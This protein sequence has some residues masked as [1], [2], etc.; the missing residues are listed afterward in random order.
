MTKSGTESNMNYAIPARDN[1]SIQIR[2]AAR[3]AKHNSSHD[4]LTSLLA[5]TSSAEWRI[6]SAN[7]DVVTPATIS[8]IPQSYVGPTRHSQP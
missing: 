8:V 6:T 4:P 7:S 1:D 5:L 2:V 3:E